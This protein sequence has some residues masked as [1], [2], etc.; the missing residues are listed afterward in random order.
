MQSGTSFA[1]VTGKKYILA[2]KSGVGQ[3]CGKK[4]LLHFYSRKKLFK[5]AY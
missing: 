5:T 1:L 4:L 3:L 2:G